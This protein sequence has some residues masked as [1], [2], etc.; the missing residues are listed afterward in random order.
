[1]GR[2]SCQLGLLGILAVDTD[3]QHH[4]YTPSATSSCAMQHHTTH[5]LTHQLFLGPCLGL[6]YLSEEQLL[7]YSMIF[8]VC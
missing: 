4:M 8:H 7:W 6:D 3:P 5:Q 2:E 1:M